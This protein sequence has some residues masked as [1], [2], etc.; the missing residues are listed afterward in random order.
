[1]VENICRLHPIYP[2]CKL[3]RKLDGPSEPVSMWQWR[4][5]FSTN[6]GNRIAVIHFWPSYLTLP[7]G[8]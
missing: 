5:N 1:M 6:I 8:L 4:E 7:T 3:H 2:W